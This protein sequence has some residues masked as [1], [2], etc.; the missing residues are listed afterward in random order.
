MKKKRV[1]IIII[2]LIA[3]TLGKIEKTEPIKYVNWENPKDR[4]EENTIYTEET[5]E[6]DNQNQH[7]SIQIP[8]YDGNIYIEINQNIPFFTEEEKIPQ[9][10]ENYSE[11][12]NL[13]RCGVAFAC[14]GQDIMPTEKRGEIGMI[15]PAGWHTVKYDCIEGKYLYNRCHLIAYMLSGENANEKNLIT[16]TRYFNTEGML[17]FESEVSD[18]VHKTGNHVL[19]R[20]TPYYTD[21]NLIANGVLME[22]ESIE[23]NGEGVR[24]N[25]FVYNVQP[26]IKIDYKTGE[27][28]EE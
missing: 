10:F 7:N 25:V 26:G 13:G 14:I 19:Y 23:D 18:Y 6:T 2:L 1:Y 16:G 4:N 27:S 5:K 3:F 15:K 22:A 21:D 11:L 28:W 12:D 20:V 8:E 24:F 9:S 17:P